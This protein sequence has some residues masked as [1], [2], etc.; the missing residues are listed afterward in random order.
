MEY[1]PKKYYIK[2]YGC[3]ANVADSGTMGG[4]LEA[5]VVEV[6][7]TQNK[8]K[9]ESEE[10]LDIL[11]QTDLFIVNSCSVRQKSED[12]VYGLG[13]IFSQLEKKPFSILS[14][15][16]VGSVT[17]K[18]QRFEFS[19]LKKKT[20]WADTYMNPSQIFDLP[21]I[22]KEY[23][24]LSDW[25][26]Q[27]YNVKDIEATQPKK[28]EAYINIS[29][30]C[31]NFCTFCVVPYARGQE[32]SR[33]EQE[34]LAEVKHLVGRGYKKI[35][36]CGQNVNSW[37]LDMTEK[38]EIRTNSDQKLPFADLL[39]KIHE[40]KGI[41]V[42]EFI[43]SNPFD[44][45]KDLIEVLKLP[46]IS[47]Y[48]HIAVQ[49]GNNEV[50]RRMNR[51][52]TIEDFVFL[53]KEIQRAKPDAELG[54]DIIVG[55]PGETEEQFMDTVD[56]F[57]KIVFKVAFISMYSPRKGTPAERMFGDD[58]SLEEKKSRHEFLTKVWKENKG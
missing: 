14:G 31:D 10:L 6:T 18:L 24:L 27:K 38:F 23:N 47:N 58:I 40:I 4:I 32:I 45:T 11:P 52:H 51:R 25:A 50:L 49:S 19:E 43:S 57:K 29:T 17:G 13:K 41:S 1:K 22:L 21:T 12:K 33:T 20:S 46:K 26:L 42:V 5:L 15:C 53:V 54:T 7:W 30:G 55:F 34:I 36:L 35:T 2:T 39:R 44:F 56:L 37:G 28:D 3:Q 9:N 8:Y 16:M 48:L